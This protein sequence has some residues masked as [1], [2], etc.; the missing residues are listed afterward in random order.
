MAETQ[1]TSPHGGPGL[2]MMISGP[3]QDAEALTPV[4]EAMTGKVWH[5]GER[6]ELAAIYKLAG[7]SVYFAITGAI[8]DVIALGRNHDIDPQDMMPVFAE[9]KPGSGL[10][11]VERR[12]DVLLL[13]SASRLPGLTFLGIVGKFALVSVLPLTAPRGEMAPVC[14]TLPNNLS[15]RFRILAVVVCLGGLQ[16]TV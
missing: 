4:L 11:L 14:S 16:L 7:N 12:I 6:P 9:F 3:K 1:T 8:A 13:P 15:P 5:V 10:H 2:L